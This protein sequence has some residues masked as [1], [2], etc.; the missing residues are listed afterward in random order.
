MNSRSSGNPVDA[1]IAFGSNLGDRLANFRGALESLVAHESVTCTAQSSVYETAPV[2]GPSG[3]GP[4]L[5]GVVAVRTTLSPEALLA[6]CQ[7]IESDLGRVRAEV[8]GPRII[9][10]DLLLY[11]DRVMES[12][13]LILP[14]PRMHVRGF[15]L[16]PMAEIAAEVVHPVLRCS[17]KELAERMPCRE[18]DIRRGYDV[19]WSMPSG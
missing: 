5:N 3:Q 2:G 14:H 7:R 17:V 19:D 10:L 8:W 13:S 9:D 6:H 16:V 4:Y 12:G 11:G 1:Y 15:V 18:G